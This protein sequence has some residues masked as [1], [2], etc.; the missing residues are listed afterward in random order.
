V[1]GGALPSPFNLIK[2]RFR[3]RF[4]GSFDAIRSSL[5]SVLPFLFGVAQSDFVRICSLRPPTPYAW[6]INSPLLRR[7]F[8]RPRDGRIPPYSNYIFLIFPFVLSRCHTIACA[9]PFIRVRFPLLPFFL[10]VLLFSMTSF[11]LQVFTP[12]GAP[13]GSRLAFFSLRAG[14]LPLLP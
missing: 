6:P 4:V 7:H 13:S 14:Y 11:E 1:R 5:F 8:V 12:P 9:P 3:L 2:S 10:V